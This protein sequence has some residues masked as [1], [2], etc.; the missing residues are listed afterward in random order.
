MTAEKSNNNDKPASP[1]E[2]F[3]RGDEMSGDEMYAVARTLPNNDPRKAEL[4]N[5]MAKLYGAVS[6][7]LSPEWG[8][9]YSEP[10]TPGGNRR[11]SLHTVAGKRADTLRPGRGLGL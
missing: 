8:S 6:E 11:K 10:I 7:R 2:K 4:E 3:K 5:A 1:A 9:R